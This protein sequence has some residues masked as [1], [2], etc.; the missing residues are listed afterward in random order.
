[1]LSLGRRSHRPRLSMK[2]DGTHT[3]KQGQSMSMFHTSLTVLLLVLPCKV[4]AETSSNGSVIQILDSYESMWDKASGKQCHSGLDLPADYNLHKPPSNFV[5]ISVGFEIRQVRQ[6]HEETMSYDLHL[7]LMLTWTDKRL[8]GQ[9]EKAGCN[10][11]FV[12][13]GNKLWVPG[14]P[15][16]MSN[17][18]LNLITLHLE[19][20]S[21]RFVFTFRCPHGVNR[22]HQL[23]L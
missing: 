3:A 9:T 2:I 5:N 4:F 15:T 1:M 6:V 12:K 22:K 21:N 20:Y 16:S 8:V 10:P 14:T 18:V 23:L 17:S 19:S 11:V 7:Q 13:E